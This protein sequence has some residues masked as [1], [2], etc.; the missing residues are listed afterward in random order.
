M[1]NGNDP[2]VANVLTE[3]TN[4]K[5]QGLITKE[6]VLQIFSESTKES[7]PKPHAKI[8]LQKIFYYIGGFI[9]LMGIVL[10]IAQFWEQMNQISKVLLTLGSAISAYL[11]GYYFFVKT[12]SKDFGHA[13]F[14]ISTPL[15]VLGIGTTLDLL[16]ISA[17][18]TD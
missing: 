3:L 2:R 14:V 6:Q 17:S 7:I 4:L 8:S 10:I 15:F 9:V 12:Q 5:N 1:N 11:I 18:A 13:F 16:Q